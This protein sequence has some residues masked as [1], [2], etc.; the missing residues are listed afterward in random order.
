[1]REGEAPSAMAVR[2]SGEEMLLPARQKS[3]HT[4]SHKMCG[5]R[6]PPLRAPKGE[7]SYLG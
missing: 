5:R 2:A 4:G 6:S 3:A 7:R 1:M